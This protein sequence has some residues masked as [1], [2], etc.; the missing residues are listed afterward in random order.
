MVSMAG[1]TT[2]S[3]NPAL[4]RAPAKAR[5]FLRS[6]KGYLLVALVAL[7]ALAEPFAGMAG[8][9]TVLAAAVVGSV[10]MELAL[11]QIGAGTWRIPSSALLTGLIVGMVLG[12][13]EPW[14]VALVAGVLAIDAKH[15]LRLG[16]SHVFNPAAFGLIAASWLFASGQSWWGA[17]AD[18]PAVAAVALLIA[19]YLVAE[20]ANKVPA[21]LAFLA[22]YAALFTATTFFTDAADI[23]ELFRPPYL[24]AALYFAV[25]MVTDPPTSPV[26]FREQAWFGALTAVA[27]FAV[28]LQTRAVYYLPAGLLI[29]NAGYAL[30]RT[31]RGLMN[32]ARGVEA[33]A[34]GYDS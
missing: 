21:A 17:L 33:P 24:Q 3:E 27:C 18:L 11:V 9:L 8:A 4:N 10:A 28:Y 15:L 7:A 20:R 1:I 5:R 13:F 31:S 12:P 14:Y 30:W 19:G 22:A 16:R 25:F 6:P 26:R 34:T 2:I 23:G 32:G 29:A